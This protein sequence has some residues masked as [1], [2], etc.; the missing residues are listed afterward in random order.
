MAQ[1]RKLPEMFNG[2][3]DTQKLFDDDPEERYPVETAESP[4]DEEEYRQWLEE[5]INAQKGYGKKNS[6]RAEVT[7]EDWEGYYNSV[8]YSYQKQSDLTADMIAKLKEKDNQRAERDHMLLSMMPMG[9]KGES[10]DHSFDQ[11]MSVVAYVFAFLVGAA[12]CHPFKATPAEIC[13]IGSITGTLGTFVKL[14][15]AER[16]PASEAIPMLMLPAWIFVYVLFMLAAGL[17]GIENA[18]P[19]RLVFYVLFM[20]FICLRF[21]NEY[22]YDKKM[23]KTKIIVNAIKML[24]IILLPPALLILKFALTQSAAEQGLMAA[25]DMEGA[26]LLFRLF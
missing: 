22:R 7:K 14:N 5:G 1:K 9:F 19:V 2:L 20:V 23:M 16:Y 25:V 18:L 17:V 24:L 3:D 6:D 4:E 13:L 26:E 11:L 10:P 15:G 12:I 21:M 8:D